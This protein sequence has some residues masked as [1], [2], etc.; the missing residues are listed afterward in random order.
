ML[1]P[2]TWV[3]H[4][5]AAIWSVS[6]D[7][8]WYITDP[9]ANFALVQANCG[10]P[11]LR[12]VREAKAIHTQA[13]AE[14]L[15]HYWCEVGEEAAR[16]EHERQAKEAHDKQVA[17]DYIKARRFDNNEMSP[18]IVS[19]IHNHQHH[20]QHLTY[21][22]NPTFIV[23]TFI[24]SCTAPPEIPGLDIKLLAANLP[25]G[26]SDFANVDR[27]LRKANLK[28]AIFLLVCLF[29]VA[30]L[31]IKIV[32]GIINLLQRLFK[33]KT[34]ARTASRPPLPAPQIL[35][36][37]SDAALRKSSWPTQAGK[38]SAVQGT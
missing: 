24:S 1:H 17:V 35:T 30:W 11:T 16:V 26:T 23:P 14:N 34:A 12:C 36:P 6:N 3:T 19:I 18:P 25:A 20:H 29:L 2:I 15:E 37:R 32:C 27:A 22:E 5:L 7:Y 31:L 9:A 13:V 33:P 4:L 28:P 10:L 8:S 38:Y 21:N